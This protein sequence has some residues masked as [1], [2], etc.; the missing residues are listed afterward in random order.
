MSY[1]DITP[2]STVALVTGANQGI[3]FEIAK[4]LA[5]ENQDYHVIVS[6]R[7]PDAVQEATS[8]LQALGL[9]VSSLVLNITSDENIAAAAKTIDDKFGRLDVL[10][11]NSAI[12]GYGM[13]VSPRELMM[14]VYNTNCIG[15]A[16]VTDAFI[17]LLERSTMTRRIVFVSTALSSLT[18]KADPANSMHSFDF[19]VYT[20]SK[21]ALNMIALHYAV[22]YENDPQWKIN[23]AC[24]G[25]NSRTALN[26]YVGTEPVDLGAI[27]SCNA[28]TLGPDG[29]TGT[30]KE[31][32]RVVPW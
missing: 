32:K 2:N 25:H 18:L 10:V 27:S 3:G 12:S 15:T 16:L 21:S 14:A 7:S 29:E 1:P 13:A 26:G 6:G 28:A 30:F 23:V 20:H 31:D 11:N 19:G 4:K 17:P 5:S 8:S 9:N 22:R 24:P